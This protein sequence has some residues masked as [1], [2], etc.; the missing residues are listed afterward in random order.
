[1]DRTGLLG[2][3]KSALRR[4]VQYSGASY[5]SR[6]T[7]LI[8]LRVSVSLDYFSVPILKDRPAVWRLF[9]SD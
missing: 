8:I 5:M 4:Q 2:E 7:R 3:L 9:N 1:M 6:V